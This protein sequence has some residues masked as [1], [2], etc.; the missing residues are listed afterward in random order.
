VRA[1]KLGLG[2]AI[3]DGFS[4]SKGNYFLILEVLAKS[5]GITV[6]EILITFINRKIGRSKLGFDEILKFIKLCWRFKNM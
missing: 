6:T 5:P 1:G 2:S 4:M 3:L